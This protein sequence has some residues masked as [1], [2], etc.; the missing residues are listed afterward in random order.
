MQDRIEYMKAL[1]DVVD[2]MKNF[3]N[4]CGG[5]MEICKNIGVSITETT[6]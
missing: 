4:L 5:L 3:S 1:A 2:I 6:M